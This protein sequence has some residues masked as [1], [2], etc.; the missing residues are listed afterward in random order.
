MPSLATPEA[1]PH[2]LAFPGNMTRLPTQVT[3][4]FMS[5]FP[6]LPCKVSSQTASLADNIKVHKITQP[7]PTIPD[8]RIIRRHHYL[9]GPLHYFPCAVSPS[10]LVKQAERVQK[11]HM[12]SVQCAF[13]RRVDGLPRSWQPLQFSS[14]ANRQ[15]ISKQTNHTKN[16]NK[17][18]TRGDKERNGRKEKRRK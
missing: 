3:P 9:D 2:G 16:N 8:R 5:L 12:A 7:P 6:T 10:A 15:R 17:E 11:R 13:N 1:T 14:V 18:E 4:H